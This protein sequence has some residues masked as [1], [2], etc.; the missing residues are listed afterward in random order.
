MSKNNNSNKESRP[1]PST[2]RRDG[3][4]PGTAQSPRGNPP[5]SGSGVPGKK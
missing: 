5:A 3:Y 1:S 4:Q 2:E